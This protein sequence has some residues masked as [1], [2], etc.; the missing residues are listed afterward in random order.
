MTQSSRAP[1][2]SL[3]GI[4]KRFDGVTALA[5]ATLDVEAGTVHGLVGQNGAG[6]STLIRILAGLHRPDAGTVTVH[7]AAQDALTPYRVEQLGI[8]FIHQDRLLV[9]SFTVGEA[10]LLGREIV[11]HRVVPLLDRRA[12]QR[13]AAEILHDYFGL[14]L[15][16]DVLISELTTAQKQIVQITRALLD[17]PSV[18]VF[19]EPTA[20]LVRR[21]ADILFALID[22]KSVV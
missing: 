12:M 16:P 18:L 7:G 1:A 8:H 22:R 21:E 9:G 19:D 6:K 20:A 2:L 3:R 5:G 14:A 17:K 13:R 11:R 4:V 15:P 10:L